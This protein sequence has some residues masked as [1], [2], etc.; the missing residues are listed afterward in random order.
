MSVLNCSFIQA[1]VYILRNDEVDLS[2]RR[3][4]QLYQW[5]ETCDFPFDILAVVVLKV[6]MTVGES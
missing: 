5:R 1:M 4:P 3:L 6:S 2:L